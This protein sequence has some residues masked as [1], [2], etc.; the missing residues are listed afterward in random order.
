MSGCNQ[1][2]SDEVQASRRNGCNSHSGNGETVAE[3]TLCTCVSACDVCLV[4][5]MKLILVYTKLDDFFF[6]FQERHPKDIHMD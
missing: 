6:S 1:L 4:L 3:G 5:M 2:T